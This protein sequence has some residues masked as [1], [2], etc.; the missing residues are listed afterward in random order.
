VPIA[1]LGGVPATATGVWLNVTAAAGGSATGLQVYPG[2]CG[3]PPASGTVAVLG[4]RAAASGT[5]LALGTNGGVCLRAGAG[6]VNAI[7]DVAGWF[8]D[9]SIEGGLVYRA[10]APTRIRSV[11]DGQVAANVTTAVT[12]DAV[13][14]LNVTAVAPAAFGHLVARPC[15]SGVTSSLLNYAPR[16]NTANLGVVAPGTANRVC[17]TPATASHVIVDRSGVFVAPIV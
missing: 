17:L 11:S 3:T 2:P 12:V 1:G 15:G 10:T 7:I 14:V 8:H 6:A 9:E 4:G 5:L 16:E 13:S